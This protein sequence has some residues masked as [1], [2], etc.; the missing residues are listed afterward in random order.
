ML[1]INDIADLVEQGAEIQSDGTIIPPKP[2]ETEPPVTETEA[3]TDT[4][5]TSAETV[6][7]A[8]ITTTYETS[9]AEESEEIEAIPVSAEATQNSGSSFAW[10]FIVIVVVVAAAGGILIYMQK[11]KKE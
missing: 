9:V 4:S 2:P 11:N 10:I 1:T 3:T 7:E 5:E 6:I 8:E